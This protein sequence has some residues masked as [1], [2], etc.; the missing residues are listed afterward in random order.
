MSPPKVVS[1][2]KMALPIRVDAFRL[3][4]S[5]LEEEGAKVQSVLE[6]LECPAVHQP[7]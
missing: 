6:Y 3:E 2:K 5:V 4:G 7:R 1:Q